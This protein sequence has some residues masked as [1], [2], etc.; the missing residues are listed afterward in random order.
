MDTNPQPLGTQQF[1]LAF[2]VADLGV[3]IPACISVPPG[4]SLSV[5]LAWTPIN[6][7]N[8]PSVSFRW[9][10]ANSTLVSSSIISPNS[11]SAAPKGS[12]SFSITNSAGGSNPGTVVYTLDVTLFNS[13]GQPG[14]TPKSFPVTFDLTATGGNCGAST[15]T[16][17]HMQRLATSGTKQTKVAQ[18]PATLIAGVYGKEHLTNLSGARKAT[19]ALPD[20]QISAKDVNYAPSV[21]KQ[22][23]TVQVR[24]RMTNA[25]TADAKQVP[26][27]LV[28][29]G[30][31]VA[32]DTFDLK[33]GASSLGAL[34][35]A[36][37]DKAGSGAV[38]ARLAV[39][40]AH[41]VVEAST[42]GKTAVLAHF[43]L[44]GTGG[45]IL[46]ALSS[47]VSHLE[48]A[49]GSCVGFRFAAGAGGG[50]GSADL[51]LTV[52]DLAEGKYVLSGRNG[53]AD[54]GVGRTDASNA[55]Y[56][57]QALV[58]PGHTYAV[59]LSGKSVGLFTVQRVRNPKQLTEKSDRTFGHVKN[60][61]VGKGSGA[62]QTGDVSGGSAKRNEAFVYFDVMYATQ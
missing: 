16:G 44:P 21:P 18:I 53:V 50:C 29:N 33:A 42:T 13:Q 2:T 59:Q 60:V 56:G 11:G 45:G 55:S 28:L 17:T 3:T 57:M 15:P 58:V 49:E 30:K 24:F 38:N 19:A 23:D 36:V 31:T 61:P 12:T 41:T 5:P 40:P 9:T 35:W 22:G 47:K 46:T 34:S 26:I 4:T 62:T 8:A 48:V 43:T 52:E 10:D 37:N 6:G 20:V 32:N 1:G 14:P 27:A 39:D 7:Y 51:E 54:L 25:G